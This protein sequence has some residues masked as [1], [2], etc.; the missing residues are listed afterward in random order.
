[1]G[2]AQPISRPIGREETHVNRARTINRTRQGYTLIEVLMATALSLMLMAGVAGVIGTVSESINDTRALLEKADQLRGTREF[3]A[4]DLESATAPLYLPPPLLPEANA[5]Y[6]QYTEGPFGPLWLPG[7]VFINADRGESDTTV[8]D[9]D[10]M[11]MFTVKRKDRPFVGR[12]LQ[13][14]AP[15]SGETPDSNSPDSVG[16]YVINRTADSFVA[17]VAWF[18]RGRTLYRRVL[19]V[20]PEFDADL[21]TDA[22]EIQLLDDPTNDYPVIPQANEGYGFFANYD[23]SVRFD[24]SNARLVANTLADLTKPENRFAH[25]TRDI[26]SGGANRVAGSFPFHPHFYRDYSSGVAGEDTKPGP[27]PRQERTS[28]SMLG[29]PTLRECS[30]YDSTTITNSWRAGGWLVPVAPSGKLYDTMT[31][32]AMNSNGQTDLWTEPHPWAEL[33]RATGTLTNAM[34]NIRRVGEDIILTNCIGFDVK[35]WDPGAPIIEQTVGARTVTLLPGDPGYLGAVGNSTWPGGAAGAPVRVSHGA[36]ADLNYM[37][38]L[39]SQNWPGVADPTDPFVREK[40]AR[41]AYWNLIRNNPNSNELEPW[42]YG[43]GDYRSGLRGQPPDN[44]TAT[45]DNNDTTAVVGESYADV[46]AWPLPSVY[47][48]WST[49]YESDG[50]NQ[51]NDGFIDEGIDA[52]DNPAIMTANDVYY[53]QHQP[54]GTPN[55]V[56]DDPTEYETSPPYP[57]PLRGIQ[58]K[59]RVYEPDSK[60][61]REVTLV[62][63][64][65]PK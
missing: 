24:T 62:Q 8:G 56:V 22:R 21:R 17:E 65:F 38:R 35:V 43:A 3:L 27:A 57:V 20:L 50:I 39:G 53:G 54:G 45:W 63:D 18:M 61:I 6:F 46:R 36:Y 2:R 42:F 23:L 37:C 16:D 49:H 5:G 13:K 44:D 30:Y 28:W 60:K 51:D 52:I 10:D 14:R 48:T 33:D 9:I 1:M 31:P 59:I 55:G 11:L 34:S 58:V 41:P 19:L 12:V 64:F 29:L 40:I 7:M 26:D 47:D 25:R 32:S 4:G 15:L